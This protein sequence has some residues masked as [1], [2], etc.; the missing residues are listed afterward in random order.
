[1]QQPCSGLFSELRGQQKGLTL[2]V[3][4]DTDAASSP[5]GAKKPCSTTGSPGLPFSGEL[6][7]FPMFP[8]HA[9]SLRFQETKPIAANKAAPIAVVAAG[10]WEMTSGT[11]HL[12]PSDGM[13]R[14]LALSHCT[15][16]FSSSPAF[17][18]SYRT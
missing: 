4:G 8:V 14:C 18:R 2:A 7:L 1:M 17:Y 5:T 9:A 6:F 11:D 3:N 15:S 13:F 16:Q 10:C 12:G